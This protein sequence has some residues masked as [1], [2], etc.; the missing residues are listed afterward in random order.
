MMVRIFI[1]TVQEIMAT[2]IGTSGAF[3]DLQDA[4]RKRQAYVPTTVGDLLNF[5]KTYTSVQSQ[6]R[7]KH[8]QYIEA[9]LSRKQSEVDKLEG[10][11][12]VKVQARKIG[13]LKQKQQLE[14]RIKSVSNSRWIL[15]QYLA[16]ID[17]YFNKKRLNSLIKTF[18]DEVSRPFNSEKH[19]LQK[20][21]DKLAENKDNFD[22][23]VAERMRPELSSYR[24]TDEVLKEHNTL[25]PGMIGESRAIQA[26]STLPQSFTVLNDVR[27][28]FRPGYRRK[29]HNDFIASVQIDHLVIGPTGIFVVETKHWSQ[30]SINSLNLRSPVEQLIRTGYAIYRFAQDNLRSAFADHWGNRKIPVTNILL[31]T[32]VPVNNDYEDIEVHHA[33]SVC[34][35]LKRRREKMSADAVRKTVALFQQFVQ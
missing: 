35:A 29:S 27:I 30:A 25:I 17:K 16:R 20:L 11:L 1:S 19:L 33:S 15:I 22:D 26:L 18:E 13:L 4:L 6:I 21:K 5:S 28:K 10:E 3:N 24:R 32:N 2:T 12:R 34:K 9:D 8:K 31:M 14:V 7:E 23:L